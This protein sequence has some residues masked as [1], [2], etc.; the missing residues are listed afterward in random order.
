MFQNGQI[1]LDIRAYFAG[2][3]NQMLSFVLRQEIRFR[4]K[5]EATLESVLN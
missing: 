3:R 1:D 2:K 4:D 5:Y